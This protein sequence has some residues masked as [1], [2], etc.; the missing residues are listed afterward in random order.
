[1]AGGGGSDEA[2]SRAALVAFE[3]EAQSSFYGEDSCDQVPI[4]H[5]PFGVELLASILGGAVEFGNGEV[6]RGYLAFYSLQTR[7]KQPEDDLR[8]GGFRRAFAGTGDDS[9][10]EEEVADGLDC[11]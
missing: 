10:L 2:E 6:L 8:Q 5:L 9:V 11:G 3:G 4:W 7:Q 1:M